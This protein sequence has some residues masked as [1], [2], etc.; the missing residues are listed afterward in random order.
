MKRILYLSNVEVPYRV[1][2]F[3]E[4]AKYCDLTVL[5]ERDK[6][7][8]RNEAWAKS[9]SRNFRTIFLN[10]VKMKKDSTFSLKIL[11][12]ILGDYD[13]II[14]GAY[15]SPVQMFAIIV[16]RI[17]HI[18]YILSTDG[19]VFLEK[20]GIKT[21]AKSFFLKGADK[22]LVAGEN[23]AHELQKILKDKPIFVYNF[24][25]LTDEE[26]Q[27]NKKN[28]PS[29]RDEHILIV[30]IYYQYKGLDVAVKVA[31]RDKETSYR[32]V[33]MGNRSEIF[34]K[35]QQ[36]ENYNNIQVIPFLPFKQLIEEMKKCKL[37]ILPS[38]KECWGL[39]IN[40]AASLGTPIV[41]TWG[42][43]AGIEFLA[44]DYPQYLAQPGDSDSLY[45]CV[46][47]LK[48]SDVSGYKQFLAN[49]AE[50]YSIE[51]SVKVHLRACDIW[52]E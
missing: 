42:C 36:T 50:K 7:T 8:N 47:N 48:K 9:E 46:Q 16:M 3:K 13:Y 20:K 35:E 33:G 39:V 12:Y 28:V 6:A 4:L 34:I 44:K 31:K 21:C 45:Q 24:S 17:L 29:N 43:G 40:E 27:I 19:K 18:P 22:Y 41:S 2:F 11:K 14:V 1:R 5:Y 26:N 49:K 32:F 15:N 25:S 37:L 52:E 51:K 30:G 23:A 38:R 10:G